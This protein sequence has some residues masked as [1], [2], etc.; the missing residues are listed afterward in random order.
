MMLDYFEVAI[1]IDLILNASSMT[2][3]IFEFLCIS[4]SLKFTNAQC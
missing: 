3:L 1:D 4:K 2:L